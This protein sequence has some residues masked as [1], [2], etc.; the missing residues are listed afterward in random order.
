[1][2]TTTI[3]LTRAESVLVRRV[4][5]RNVLHHASEA[6]T[7]AIDGGGY[8]EPDVEAVDREWANLVEVME[9][10]AAITAGGEV[11]LDDA[12]WDEIVPEGR[13]YLIST[14][15]PE[16]PGTDESVRLGVEQLQLWISIGDKL[17]AARG[18][19]AA[20]V[21][22]ASVSTAEETEAANIT[23]DRPE[24]EALW[25][26]IDGY[27]VSG[28]MC[29]VYGLIPI[30]DLGRQLADAGVGAENEDDRPDE[31]ELRCPDLAAVL[32]YLKEAFGH[33]AQYRDDAIWRIVHGPDHDHAAMEWTD[34]IEEQ[35]SIVK[36]AS[37][38]GR[39]LAAAAAKFSAARV[40]EITAAEGRAVPALRRRAPPDPRGAACRVSPLPP[41]D[42]RRGGR[43]MAQAQA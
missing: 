1:M 18:G 41:R 31:V 9:A 8:H 14:A 13:D 22:E 37:E 28:G 6:F 38:H 43:L 11:T 19:D 29:D 12:V 17:K 26:R 39:G 25:E 16:G 15:L 20:E 4:F 42:H 27:T 34:W 40:A 36:D 33:N 7:D 21:S 3:G 10:D 23:L 32:R 5:I 30:L 35:L 24:A 2:A